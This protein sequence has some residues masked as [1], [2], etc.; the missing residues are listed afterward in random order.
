MSRTRT[1]AERIKG[2]LPK[3]TP[4]AHKT[5]TAGGIANDVG[6]VTL[7]DGRRFAIA[8][9]TNSNETSVSDRDRAIAE[10]SRMLF[11]YFYLA[12]VAKQ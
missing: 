1:G 3:G 2:L 4:V 5:G 9:F 11:D 7:P 8:V 12:P 6:Y 10:I